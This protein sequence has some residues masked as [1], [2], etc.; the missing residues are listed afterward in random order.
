[1]NSSTTYF[2]PNTLV[3]QHGGMDAEQKRQ[4]KTHANTPTV[5]PHGCK[6]PARRI[7]K[8]VNN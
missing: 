1:M 7:A 8:Q 6:L 3:A 5:C 2:A 4:L